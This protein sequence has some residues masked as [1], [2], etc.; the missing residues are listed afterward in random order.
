MSKFIK[1]VFAAAALSFLAP[2]MVGAEEPATKVDEKEQ[3]ELEAKLAEARGRLEAAAREVAE[4]SGKVTRPIAQDF[5]IASRMHGG[6][7]LG[8]GIGERTDNK[9]GAVV[10]TVMP[11]GPA[12]KAG[13]KSGDVIVA[14]D[15]KSL[16]QDGAPGRALMKHM[17]GVSPGQKVKVEYLRDGKKLTTEIT[18]DRFDHDWAVA[19]LDPDGGG[20]RIKRFRGLAP[21]APGVPG[22]PAAPGVPGVP[23]MAMGPMTFTQFLGPNVLDMELV[24]LT[25]KL[26]SYFGAESGVLVVRA[27]S[28]A[29]I[30]LQEG[31]VILDIDGREPQTG[32]H[33]MRILRSYQPGEQVKFN[34]LRDRKPVKVAVTVPESDHL[35]RRHPDGPDVLIQPKVRAFKIPP[36]PPSREESL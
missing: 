10:Q 34:V 6:A 17:R 4:L 28:D 9:D 30:K 23:G 31:D 25:P 12:S 20:P 26:G 16:T 15:G 35:I 3:A 33:A 19:G 13:I 11:D 29:S 27:P 24:T 18:A 32:M 1:S 14:V 36:P 21:M 7:M 8:V 2:L 22:I 5:F